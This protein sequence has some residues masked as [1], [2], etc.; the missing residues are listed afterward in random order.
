MVTGLRL[1]KLDKPIPVYNLEVEDFQSY[2]VG[3]GVLVHNRC[4]GDQK[5]FR[6]AARRGKI[7]KKRLSKALHQHKRQEGRGGADHLT[8]KQLNKLIDEIDSYF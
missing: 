2:F 1:E 6:D 4:K 8:W 7:D 3:N 5:Q